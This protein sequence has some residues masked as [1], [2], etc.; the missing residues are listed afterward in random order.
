MNI[1]NYIIVYLIFIINMDNINKINIYTNEEK[2][3][4]EL[5]V[6]PPNMFSNIDKYLIEIIKK[7]Y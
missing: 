1:Y 5:I 4:S 2:D 7:V 6:V 3:I